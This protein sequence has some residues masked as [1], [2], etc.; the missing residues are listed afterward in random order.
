MLRRLKHALSKITFLTSFRDFCLALVYPV[1]NWMN[2][3]P[4]YKVYCTIESSMKIFKKGIS[5]SRYGDGELRW[6]LD[7]P[8]THSFQKNDKLL[9]ERLTDI[10]EGSTIDNFDIALPELPNRG[11]GYKLSEQIAWRAFWVRY[12]NRLKPLIDSSYIYQN[13]FVTRPYMPYKMRIQSHAVEI[14]NNLKKSWNNK[15]ILIIEGKYTR[16]GVGD[17]LLSNANEVHRI[18]CPDINAFES[19]KDIHNV[20]LETCQ[21]FD[22]NNL[23]VLVAL[24]PTATVLCYDLTKQGIQA[25]DIGHTDIEY[26]W[27]R[28]HARKKESV[29][30]KYVNEAKIPFIGEL[31]QKDEQLYRQQI[32]KTI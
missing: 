8:V 10:F 28:S 29:R 18:I 30:G 3:I 11:S 5:L 26:S 23:I 13:S 27:Y 20:A 16:F 24:G 19:Y 14:F 17:D 25:V 6:L 32:I 9:S 4:K 1:F 12:G 15:A 7:V 21:F 31:N 22:L 2:L